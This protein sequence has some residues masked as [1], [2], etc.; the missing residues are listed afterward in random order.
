ML[1]LADHTFTSIQTSSMAPGL[2]SVETI[3]SNGVFKTKSQ[4]SR[5]IFPDGIKT[6][7]QHPPIYDEIR[8]FEDFPEFIDA[9]TLWKAK[10]YRDNPERWVHQFSQEEIEEMSTAV[11]N[12]KAAGTPLTGISKVC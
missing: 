11:D 10:D 9:P 1:F 3:T 6:S 12:F 8:G 4:V 2:T 5:I 7:G